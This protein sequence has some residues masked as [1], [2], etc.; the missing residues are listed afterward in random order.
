MKVTVDIDITPQEARQVVGLPDM[1]PMQA[2]VMKEFEKRMMTEMERIS[3]EGMIRT[4]FVEAP[5]TAD[6]FLKMFTGLRS[7]VSSPPKESP[8]P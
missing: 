8:K 5:Q 3:P 6:R 4:W 2:A 1:Q 7:T